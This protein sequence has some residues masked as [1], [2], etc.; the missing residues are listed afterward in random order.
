MSENPFVGLLA[1]VPLLISRSAAPS[2]VFPCVTLSPSAC[3]Q[4]AE[5]RAAAVS[6]KQWRGGGGSDATQGSREHRGE[7]HGG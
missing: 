7:R 2:A 1:R 4:D 5:R 3:R 6:S